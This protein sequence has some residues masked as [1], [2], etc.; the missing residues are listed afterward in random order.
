MSRDVLPDVARK[1]SA[2]GLLYIEQT[3]QRICTPR[4]PA[5]TKCQKKVTT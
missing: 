5:A 3:W 2:Q 4:T 1:F